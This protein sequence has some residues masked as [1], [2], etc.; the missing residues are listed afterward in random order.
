MH[1]D[2]SRLCMPLC[3]PLCRKPLLF[4]FANLTDN[5]VIEILDDMKWSNTDEY[6]DASPQT[7]P[8]NRNSYC[9]QPL[10]RRPSNQAQHG[11]EVIDYLFFLSLLKPEDVSCFRINNMGGT[12]VTVMELALV[13]CQIFFLFFRLFQCYSIYGLNRVEPLQSYLINRFDSKL[14]QSSQLRNLLVSIVRSQKLLCI[15]QQFRLI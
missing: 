11:N 3:P 15:G 5:L 2:S 13:N 1:R 10:P 14:S 6:G 9:K 4:I 12:F 7:L 8:E